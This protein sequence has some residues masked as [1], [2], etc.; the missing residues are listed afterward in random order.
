MLAP[1]AAACAEVFAAASAALLP[2]PSRSHYLFTLR[3]VGRVLQVRLGNCAAMPASP[4][5]A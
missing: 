4:C 1:L 2:T 5:T 3:D